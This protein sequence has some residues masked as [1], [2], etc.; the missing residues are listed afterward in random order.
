MYK[1][2]DYELVCFMDNNVEQTKYLLLH[3]E[4][5]IRKRLNLKCKNCID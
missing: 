5:L 4:N 3:F 2:Q 1:R